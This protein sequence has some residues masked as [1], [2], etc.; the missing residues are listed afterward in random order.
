MQINLKFLFFWKKYHN[1]DKDEFTMM[2]KT[3]MKT[4]FPGYI[5]DSMGEFNTISLRG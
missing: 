3:Q 5:S 2:I 4:Y 1:L